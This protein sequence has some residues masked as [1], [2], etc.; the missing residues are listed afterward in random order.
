MTTLEIIAAFMKGNT[1]VTITQ[2]QKDWLI[3]TALNEGVKTNLTGSGD[4]I[5]LNDCHYSINQCKTRCSGG[6]YVGT[7]YIQGKYNI[8]KMY[9][10][11][12]DSNGMTEV[13]SETDLRYIRTTPHTFSI[14]NFL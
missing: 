8:E 1:K 5:Y 14:I 4:Y 13:R 6:S 7:R 12:F 3:R 9:R 10:I 11:R 2:K